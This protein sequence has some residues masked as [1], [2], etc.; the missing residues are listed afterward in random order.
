MRELQAK[1]IVLSNTE[2]LYT[3]QLI[4]RSTKIQKYCIRDTR[5][6]TKKRLMN[7]LQRKIKV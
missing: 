1:Q 6:L 2:Q 5:K 7:Q 4:R 3:I